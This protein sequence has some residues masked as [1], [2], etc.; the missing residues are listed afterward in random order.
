MKKLILIAMLFAG[1]TDNSE[2]ECPCMVIG[3]DGKL[4]TVKGIHKVNW[5]DGRFTF[6]SQHNYQ[7]GDTIK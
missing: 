3:N 1:C 2:V 5:S 7:I 6:Y 4:I